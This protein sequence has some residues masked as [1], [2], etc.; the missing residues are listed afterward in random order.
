[1]LAAECAALLRAFFERLR[2]SGDGDDD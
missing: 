1:V 2:D